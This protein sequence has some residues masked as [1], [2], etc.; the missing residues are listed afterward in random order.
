MSRTS[1]LDDEQ[2]TV[3][4]DDYAKQLKP[5]IDAMADGRIDDSE[6]AAQEERVVKLMRE[7]E[8]KLDDSIHGKVTQLLCELSAFNA[9]QT[10]HSLYEARPKSTFRG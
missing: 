3:R 1:W 2:K 8:P 4:I 5:F 6:L 9:M 10:L 7:V